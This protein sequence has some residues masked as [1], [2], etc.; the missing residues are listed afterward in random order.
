MINWTKDNHIEWI[1][2]S[3]KLVKEYKRNEKKDK[4]KRKSSSLKKRKKLK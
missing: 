4:T 3:D 2:I 1:S